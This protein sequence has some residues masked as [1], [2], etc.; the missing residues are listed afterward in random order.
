[1]TLDKDKLY[2]LASPY[3]KYPGG[4]DRAFFEV[5]RLAGKLIAEGCKVYSPIAH[6]HAIAIHG[7]LDPYDHLVWLPFNA[8][9]MT[10]CD[11][12]IVAKLDSWETSYGVKWEI[13]WFRA[14]KGLEPIYL[15]PTY[16]R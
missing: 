13:D 1:M 7:D 14:N 4:I 10:K 12:I 2:Y 9:I 5:C 6:T 16:G 11:G 8:A 15:E 3:S